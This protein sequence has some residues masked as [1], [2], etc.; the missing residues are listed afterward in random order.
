MS[1]VHQKLVAG[2]G[3][4]V[5]SIRVRR[6]GGKRVLSLIIRPIRKVGYGRCWRSVNRANM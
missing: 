3:P 1:K 6:V 2:V 5:N 4:R